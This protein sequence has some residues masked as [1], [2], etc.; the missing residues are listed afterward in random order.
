MKKLYKYL[1]QSFKAKSENR[2]KSKKIMVKMHKKQ[3]KN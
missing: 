1:H 3:E 2:L